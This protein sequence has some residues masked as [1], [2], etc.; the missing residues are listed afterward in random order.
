MKIYVKQE[1]IKKV[2][3]LNGK[4]SI[5]VIFEDI[6]DNET[7]VNFIDFS[8]A[9]K[10][11]FN[12]KENQNFNLVNIL[13]SK[14]EQNLTL[15]FNLQTKTN[16]NA[17]FLN[18]NESSSTINHNL[19]L[20][21]A[22]SKI[23]YV[24]SSLSFGKQLK[25]DIILSSHKN[26]RTFSNVKTFS[27]AKDYS[28]QELSCTSAIEQGMKKSQA[29]QELRL[30]V[31]DKTA[32]AYSD[33]ILLINENDIEASHANA[34]GNID[35]NELFYLNARGLNDNEAKKLICMGYFN[36]VLNSIKFKNIK[37]EIIKNIERKL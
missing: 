13:T 26:K 37:E 8:E 22:L 30:L 2:N 6:S 27:I 14:T 23:N 20:L 9:N 32:K 34:V 3:Y 29:H 11:N 21:G 10:I 15:N 12:F 35:K 25:K 17:F 28:V 33:P 16:I 31:F 1:D 5:D 36:E 19:N 24:G 18:L 4:E 7:V